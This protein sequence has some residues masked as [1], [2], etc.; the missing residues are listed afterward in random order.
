MMTTMTTAEKQS[1]LAAVH[2]GVLGIPRQDMGPLT[3]PVWYDYQPGGELWFITGQDSLKASLLARGTRISMCA[4]T[5]DP[6]YKYVSVE[7]SILS[8]A[9]PAGE[10]LPMAVRYLGEKMGKAYH[11]QNDDQANIVVRMLPQQWLAVDYGKATSLNA[12]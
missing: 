9:D 6:P 10:G 4:Q 7:G 12:P 11:A 1:F 2:V 3:V 5:E 8:L